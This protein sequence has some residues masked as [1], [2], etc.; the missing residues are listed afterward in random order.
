MLARQVLAMEFEPF[1]QLRQL[2][3]STISR[4]P[5][6]FTLAMSSFS[7]SSNQALIYQIDIKWGAGKVR[8][9]IQV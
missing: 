7:V 3:F 6:F 4:Q 1:H 2:S 8:R 9:L 5:P